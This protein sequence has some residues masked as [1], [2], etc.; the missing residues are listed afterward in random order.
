MATKDSG[1]D[2]KNWRAESLR[3]TLFAQAGV[4]LPANDWWLAVVGEPPESKTERLRES[5]QTMEGHL[6]KA[7]LIL[8]VFA[9]RVDWLV[10]FDP[11]L[12]QELV[13]SPNIGPYPEALDLFGGKI[14][15]W[16]LKGSPGVTRIAWGAALSQPVGDR[17]AG[18]R[19]LQEYL[20]S[21]KIDSENSSDLLYQ[22]NRPRKSKVIEGL[23]VNRLQKWAVLAVHTLRVPIGATQVQ[24]Q[25]RLSPVEHRCRVE[26]DINTAEDRSDALPKER[27]SDQLLELVKIGDEILTNGDIP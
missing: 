2:I 9:N 21:L 24:V 20:P 22:I 15:P 18:Y 16:L 7:K 10:G 1:I 27:V 4:E 23:T 25:E 3:L 19:K 14:F 11:N 17:V 8:N 13:E 12:D 5:L 26:L 6:G